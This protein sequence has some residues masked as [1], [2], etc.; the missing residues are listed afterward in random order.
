MEEGNEKA[1]QLYRTNNSISI[2]SSNKIQVSLKVFFKF[3]LFF[4]IFNLTYIL[5]FLFSHAVKLANHKL[6]FILVYVKLIG[7]SKKETYL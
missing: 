6:N 3:V 7:Y 1:I 4:L 5:T 2:K